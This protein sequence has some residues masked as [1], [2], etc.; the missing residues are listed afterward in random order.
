[1]TG[2]EAM[3]AMVDGAKIRHTSWETNRYL[4]LGVSG[5]IRPSWTKTLI[6]ANLDV[7][8]GDGWEVFSPGPVPNSTLAWEMRRLCKER[9]VKSGSTE[10]PARAAQYA[11]EA[12]VYAHCAQMVEEG[13]IVE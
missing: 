5:I 12:A 11:G 6:E 1:M 9:M 8:S 3:H 10:D 4:Y 7:P 13:R 2:K